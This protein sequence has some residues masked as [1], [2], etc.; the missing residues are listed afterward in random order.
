MNQKQ[1]LMYISQVSFGVT[2]AV[3]YLDTHPCD[4]EAMSY[5]QKMRK[6]RKEALKKYQQEF[7]PLLSD[8][9]EDECHWV[10]TETPWP[11]QNC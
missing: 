8:A 7:G 4:A 9:N 10:W 6:L 1:L 3:L 11:W 2:E 5:Y